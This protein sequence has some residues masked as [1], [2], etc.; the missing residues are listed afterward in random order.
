MRIRSTVT[1]A[2]TGL[3]LGLGA[4]C[5]W[6]LWR[7]LSGEVD[8][9]ARSEL[10][11]NAALYSYLLVGTCLVLALAGATAGRLADRLL[12]ANRQLRDLASTDALTGIKNAG[13]FRECLAVECARVERSAQ[14]LSLVMA[15][16]DHFKALNDQFGHAEGDRALIHAAKLISSAVRT[17]DIVCRVGGEEFAVICTSC[18]LEEAMR[19]GERIRQL[20]DTLPL[21][22]GGEMVRVTTS[23]GVAA[24]QKGQSWRALFESADSALYR[25][26]HKGRNRVEGSLDDQVPGAA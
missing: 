5:G 12:Q 17:G 23:V 14:P 2:V 11:G 15:D 21:E 10:Q 19:V 16:L 8:L 24:Y 18:D 1:Y 9:S 20:L 25:A 13:Y 7:M 4:P 22:L 6:L 3:L 26:K